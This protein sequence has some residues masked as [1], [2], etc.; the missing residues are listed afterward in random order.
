MMFEYGALN[1]F[2]KSVVKPSDLG[3]ADELLSV[4]AD[5]NEQ[6]RAKLIDVAYELLCA[7]LSNRACASNATLSSSVRVE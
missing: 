5:L 6:D 1:F 4:L 2:S 7:R 3:V